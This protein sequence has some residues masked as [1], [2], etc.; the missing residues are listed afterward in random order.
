MEAIHALFDKHPK[1]AF[2]EVYKAFDF[3]SREQAHLF[4]EDLI[5]KQILIKEEVGLSYFVRMGL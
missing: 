1:L 2:E 4:L 3:A 5:G